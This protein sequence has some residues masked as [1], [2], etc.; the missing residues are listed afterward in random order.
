MCLDDSDEDGDNDCDIDNDNDN[1][2][3]D[4]VSEMTTIDGDVGFVELQLI[5]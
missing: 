4:I 2:R 1:D 5:F 3:H